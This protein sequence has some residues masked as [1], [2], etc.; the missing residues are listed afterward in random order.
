MLS[1]C[2]IRRPDREDEEAMHLLRW[3]ARQMIVRAA[4]IEEFLI[5][6]A[7]YLGIVTMIML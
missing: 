7:T 3:I 5:L 4:E 6:S 2:R 1:N